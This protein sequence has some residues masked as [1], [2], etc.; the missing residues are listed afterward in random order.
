[1]RIVNLDKQKYSIKDKLA[2]LVG[3]LCTMPILG[4]PLGGR[5]ITLFSVVFV[6]F[7]AL[8]A[9]SAFSKFG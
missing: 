7:F 9:F 4:L 1:M 3:I 8:T 5:Y 2:F 6:L